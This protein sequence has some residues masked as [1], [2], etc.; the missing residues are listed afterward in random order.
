M[1]DHP[2][3]RPDIDGLRAIAVLAVLIFHAFPEVLPGG[4]VGVDVFFVISGYLITGIILRDLERQQFSLRHFYAQRVR[5][6]FPALL[7]VLLFC[8]GVGWLALTSGEYKQMGRY[9]AGGAAFLNNFLFWRDAGY[10]DSAADS[11]PLLHLWSLAIEEQFYIFWPLLLIVLAKLFPKDDRLKTRAL[12]LIG[13]LLVVFFGLSVWQVQSDTVAAFYSPLCR[14][15]ELLA[16]AALA[17]LPAKLQIRRKHILSLLGLVFL[18]AAYALIDKHRAFPGAWALLPVL[19][20]GCLIAAGGE[21]VVNRKLLANRAMVWVGLISYPL[22]LW[23][24]PLLSFIRIFEAQTPSAAIRVGLLIV[25][26]VLAYLTYRWIE[27][28][29]RLLKA[30]PAQKRAVLWGLSLAMIAM[31]FIGYGIK[32]NDG[33]KFRH[34]GRLNADASTIVIGADRELLAHECGLSD[35]QIKNFG[36]EWCLS[37]NKAVPARYAIV[38]DSKA[39]ALYYGI[40]REAPATSNVLLMGSLTLV[41]SVLPDQSVLAN[42]RA[43][44]ALESIKSNSTVDW[45]IL[46]NTLVHL[47]TTNDKGLIDVPPHP[48]VMAAHLQHYEMLVDDLE[49]SGKHVMIV[50]DNPTLPDPN[51]CIQG[52]LTPYAWLNRVVYRQANPDC[53]F[54]YSD[55]MIGTAP[56]RDFFINLANRRPNIV[57]F[58]TSPYLCD[59]AKD[60]CTYHEDKQFLYSY[61]NH[62]SDVASSKIA[63]KI[64]LKLQ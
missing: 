10:F 17:A 34:Y 16:G 21:A 61:G 2:T 1:I 8:L 18:I 11:K 35:E 48:G 42:K 27:R 44:V 28:P 41:N 5:R 59:V 49:R 39:E 31:L 22:Y 37:Q 6:I 32:Q 19:G 23:H 47:V 15:W 9:V 25:S 12:W 60:N 56:Y 53:S 33:L 63:K 54:R 20:S 50:L 62:I 26:A 51:S 43:R 46:S 38:G 13:G 3:Y 58:D 30:T 7:L 36:F 14:S 55:H 52:D 45:V 4:F 29:I 57:L 40:A 64:L 24:W